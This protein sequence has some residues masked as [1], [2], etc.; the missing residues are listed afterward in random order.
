MSHALLAPALTQNIAELAIIIAAAVGLPVTTLLSIVFFGFSFAKDGLLLLALYSV[1]LS[2]L[3]DDAMGVI[4]L[5]SSMLVYLV[6]DL[7]QKWF[8]DEGTVRGWLQTDVEMLVGQEGRNKVEEA[9]A[10]IA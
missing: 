8:F 1:V 10:W 4:G 3:G 2:L 7:V 6:V 9:F 5:G